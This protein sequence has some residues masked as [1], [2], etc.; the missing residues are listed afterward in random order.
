MSLPLTRRFAQAALLIG[1]AA[2][3]LI[4]AG[5]AQAAALPP[6]DLGGLTNLDGASVGNTVD[7]ASQQA[8]G[9]AGQTGSQAMKSTLPAT[10]RIV[11]TASKTA[12][13]AAQK[14]AGDAADAAGRIVGQTAE[15]A[16]GAAPSTETLPVSA[17]PNTGEL[18]TSALPTTDMLPLKG[19]PLG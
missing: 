16:G 14:T 10:G 2:A 15:S 1:A 11:G 3:P 9:L 12:A 6:T 4:G 7:G 18:P 19:L 8:T 17:L 5:A 13:P